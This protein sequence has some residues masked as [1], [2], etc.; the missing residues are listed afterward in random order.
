MRNINDTDAVIREPLNQHE[1]MRQLFV[2]ERGRRLIHCNDARAMVQGFRNLHHLALCDAETRHRLLQRQIHTDLRKQRAGFGAQFFPIDERRFAPLAGLVAKQNIFGNRQRR[3]EL[4]ILI[5][6]ADA[7][8]NRRR[9][10]SKMPLR[11]IHPNLAAVG[12][13]RAGHNFD[14]RRFARAVFTDETM[15]FAAA[16]VKARFIQCHDAGIAFG[17]TV[18]GEDI[19]SYSRQVE[20]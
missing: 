9:R 8:T 3:H 13:L 19:V 16:Q 10:I 20:F 14:E 4:E 18:E 5:D 15:Y 7:R 2:G 11:A 12:L 1:Q 6:H 17:D